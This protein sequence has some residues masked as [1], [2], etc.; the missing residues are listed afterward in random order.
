MLPSSLILP[1]I[2]LQEAEEKQ[3]DEAAS[4]NSSK[5][6]KK[7]NARPVDLDPHGEKLIQVSVFTARPY[8]NMSFLSILCTQ[9]MTSHSLV[10]CYSFCFKL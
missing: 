6:G 8:I 5:S 7:Q 1:P 2:L 3:E 4:S 9:F 10:S